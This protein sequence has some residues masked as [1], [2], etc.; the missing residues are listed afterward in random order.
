MPFIP[1]KCPHCNRNLS[2]IS[3]STGPKLRCI[4]CMKLW[5]QEEYQAIVDG[6]TVSLDDDQKPTK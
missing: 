5:T 3:T 6:K 1:E 4:T 2:G